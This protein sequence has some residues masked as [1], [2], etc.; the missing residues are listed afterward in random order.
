MAASVSDLVSGRDPARRHCVWPTPPPRAVSLGDR[1]CPVLAPRR[2]VPPL[3]AALERPPP[4]GRT[5]VAGAGGSGSAPPFPPSSHRPSKSAARGALPHAGIRCGAARRGRR[6][7]RRATRP[8]VSPALLRHPGARLPRVGGSRSVPASVGFRARSSAR[9]GAE[10]GP[11]GVGPAKGGNGGDAITKPVALGAGRTVPP[12]PRRP[13]AALRAVGG[14]LGSPR[15]PPPLPGEPR[16]ADPS[17]RT[18]PQAGSLRGIAR[19]LCV[20]RFAGQ[21][22][23]EP[24]S[25]PDPARARDCQKRPPI[26]CVRPRMERGRVYLPI[27][28]VVG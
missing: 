22:V 25:P 16:G 15:G 6:G 14:G 21:N 10:G 12:H 23:T 5:S 4:A 28:R 18:G 27:V 19:V 8:T 3:R 26:L 20:P 1:P 9:R 13:E 2:P 17:R 24:P 11:A 7:A